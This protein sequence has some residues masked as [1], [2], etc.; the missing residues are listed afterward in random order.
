MR[1]RTSETGQNNSNKALLEAG[2]IN[3]F[4]RDFVDTDVGRVPAQ[5]EIVD[6]YSIAEVVYGVSYSSRLFNEE[7]VGLPLIRIREIGRD[8][9]RVFTPEERPNATIVSRGDIVCGMDGEFRVQRWR[10]PDAVLNQRVCHFRPRDGVPTSFL[11]AAVKRPISF[12]ERSKTGTTVIHLLKRDIDLM[13]FAKPPAPLLGAFDREVKR[14]VRLVLEAT[15]GAFAHEPA[16]EIRKKLA[17][18]A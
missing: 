8:D 9:P 5:W 12:F 17:S 13:R 1:P 3:E 11:D 6:I 7:G 15:T 14:Q 16:T 2:L 4:C 18:E 10:G